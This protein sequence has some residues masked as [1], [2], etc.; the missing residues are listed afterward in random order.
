MAGVQQIEHAVGEH[1]VLPGVA[2][3]LDERD[4]LGEST[5][6]SCASASTSAPVE[7]DRPARTSSGAAAGRCRRPACATSR[8]R[9]R[10]AGDS[11]TDSRRACGPR[12]RACRCL[13]RDR[14]CRWRTSTSPSPSMPCGVHLFEVRVRAVAADAVGVEEADAEHEIVGRL[15][16]RGPSGESTS[17]SPEWKTYDG[18]AVCVQQRHAR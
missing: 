14:G 17:R 7:P 2:Q 11:R 10:A 3:M 1:D 13:R 5:G 18:L 12:R 16:G 9:C 6:S 8:G 4:G 15:R